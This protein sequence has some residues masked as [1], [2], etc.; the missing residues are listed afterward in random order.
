MRLRRL[1][2]ARYGKF[3]DQ[4]ID[5]GERVDGEPDLHIVYGPNE[6]GKSTAFNAFL[7][8]LFGIEL[9]SRY[10]FLHPYSTM[11]VG[12]CLELAV[13][14]RD[15]IRIKRP[16]PT[17]RDAAN[18]PVAEGLILGDLS[19]LDRNAYRTMFSL[20]DDTLEAGGKSILDSKGEL[21]QLLFSAS[22]GLSD[23]SNS[24]LELRSQADGFTRPNARNSE[25]QQFKAALVS[26]KQERD[27]IDTFASE[28]NRLAAARDTATSQYEEALEK[29]ARTQGDLGKTRRLLA[30]LPLVAR[31]HQ[32]QEQLEPFASL[33][34]APPGW[35]TELPALQQ[36]E[37]KHRSETELTQAEVKRLSDEIAAIATDEPALRLVGRLDRL[38]ELRARHTTAELD[39]PSRRRELVRAD[40]DVAG[41]L[42]RLGREDEQEPAR[43]LLNAASHPP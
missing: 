36:G 9:H 21:G 30:A 4:T 39:L 7:D 33:P 23:L 38:T 27:A 3:T 37:N 15:L 26:L 40:A 31:L 34:E 25:L 16:N 41:I 11:R 24:L 28:Y 1:D 19:G 5:F 10:G 20:D 42:T 17:L 13:G 18:Q 32:L 12:G 14:P 22:A 35:L 43:L 8:L 2:L 29:R 6:A